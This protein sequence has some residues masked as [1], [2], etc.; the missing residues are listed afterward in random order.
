MSSLISWD[1]LDDDLPLKEAANQDLALKAA[2]SLNSLD[3][4][5]ANKELDQQE[6]AIKH[7]QELKASGLI[8][9]TGSDQP[10]LNQTA[11]YSQ[12]DLKAL[13]QSLLDKAKLIVQTMDAQ[14][15]SGGRVNVAEKYLLNCQADLNQLVPFKYNWAWSLYLTSCENHW[16]PGELSLE[17]AKVDID[18]IVKGTPKKMLVR[19]FINYIYRLRDFS[20]AMLLN[21]YRMITNPEARQYILRQGFEN[22]IIHHAMSDIEDIFHPKNIMVGNDN[23]SQNQW[24]IDKDTFVSRGQLVRQLTPMLFDFQATTQGEENTSAFLEQLIYAYGYTNW[25][26]QIVPTYQL[27]NALNREGK[28]QNFGQLVIRLLKDMQAQTTFASL[29]ISVALSE[30]PYALTNEFKARVARNFKKF[31]DLECDLASTLANTDTEYTDVTNLVKYYI[32]SFLSSIGIQS[33]VTGNIT[34]DN[35]WFANM[36]ASVQP[37]VNHEAGLSGNGGSLDW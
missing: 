10:L 6:A 13:N 9:P 37:H 2:A 5:E 31:Y 32:N 21:C 8:P 7:S 11:R 35:E 3:V 19:F 4:T 22:S 24:L 33:E 36:V 30:N 23:I 15:E 26:M 25:I 17:N 16:M 12:N 14:L 27:M 34:A 20:D 18:N 28:G 1:D 29:F